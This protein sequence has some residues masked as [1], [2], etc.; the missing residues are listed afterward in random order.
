MLAD[1]PR[2]S[3]ATPCGADRHQDFDNLFECY[4][5]AVV[6]FFTRRGFSLDD[7]RDLAQDTFVRVHK[8]LSRFRGGTSV[9]SWLFTIAANV[10]R[11]ALRDRTAGK[12]DAPEVSLEA[13]LEI[14][15]LPLLDPGAS[16]DS[17]GPLADYLDRERLER[18]RL[19]LAE[20]PPQM[21]RCLLL[22]IDQH[23]KYREIAKTLKI[24]I[25][26]VKSTLFQARER[27][28][29]ELAPHYP[30]IEM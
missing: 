15:G 8:G 5:L 7:G 20:L 28:K 26:T 27:L 24:S 9:E 25:Q 16:R 23:L 13:I 2:Q 11:S 1:E 17:A 10:W 19:G 18:L 21:R 12:R 14:G 30:E 4:Y 29:Q 3:R 6:E 22:R